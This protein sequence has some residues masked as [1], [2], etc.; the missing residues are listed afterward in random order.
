MKASR[1]AVGMGGVVLIGL[2]SAM[3]VTNPSSRDY[4]SFA[5]EHLTEYLKDNACKKL[6][7]E[8]GD[9]GQQWCQTLG[10]TAIDT[11]RPQLKQIIAQQTERRNFIVFSVYR[12]KLNLPPFP[13]YEFETLGFLQ[14]F[15]TY[16]SEEL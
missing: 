13:A 12:T 8:L 9:F 7:K 2:G 1:I 11:G 6:P 16:R 5:V 3:A 10:K 4:E 15:Y 14:Q